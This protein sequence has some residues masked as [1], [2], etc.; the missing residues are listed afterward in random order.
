MK[1]ITS[2]ITIAFLIIAMNLVAQKT[3][4]FT[5]SRD[6]KTYKTIKIGTQTW[7]AENLAYKAG[8]GCWTYNDS[9]KE[10][11]KYGY[12]YN[13]KAAV[14]ACPKGWHLP[15]DGE[16]ATLTD[17]LGGTV[18]AGTKMK[19]KSGWNDFE[20]KTGNGTNTSGFAALPGGY[21][22]GEDSTNSYVGKGGYWWSASEDA[23]DNSDNVE[24]YNLYFENGDVEEYNGL[25]KQDGLSVRC[26]K[27]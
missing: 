14:K 20:G 17:N 21:L 24:T 1:N 2:L 18:D 19:T 27:N 11:T 22:S 26:V 5:D 16:W 8:S 15:S 4:T 13:W 6:K 23:G 12:L 9:I 7:M 10:A 3:S 25:S